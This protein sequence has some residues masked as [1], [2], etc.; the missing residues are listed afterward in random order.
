MNRD[1][2]NQ[3]GLARSWFR[4][5]FDLLTPIAV[6]SSGISERIHLPATCQSLSGILSVNGRSELELKE[7][8]CTAPQ[9]VSV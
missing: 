1:H 9:L 6:P 8:F 5:G 4:V 7:L 3:Q 2:F